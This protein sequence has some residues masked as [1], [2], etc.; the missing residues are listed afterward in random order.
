[1]ELG[2]R[3]RGT[4]NYP[5]KSAATRET[6]EVY[7][8]LKEERQAAPIRSLKI[9][10]YP[11]SAGGCLSAQPAA[12]A[13]S[14]LLTNAGRALIVAL[15]TNRKLAVSLTQPLAMKR[16]TEIATEER[17]FQATTADPLVRACSLRTRLA[18]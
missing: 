8:C 6:N 9:H 4:G 7:R 16:L 1:M 10:S 12:P 17:E 3:R 14:A 2:T 11:A 5:K 15:R 13:C 18:C